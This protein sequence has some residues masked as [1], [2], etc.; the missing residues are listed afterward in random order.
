MKNYFYII[1]I[2]FSLINI[3][4]NPK[5]DTTCIKTI[6]EGLIMDGEVYHNDLRESIMEFSNDSISSDSLYIPEFLLR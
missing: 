4:F 5:K 6:E 3:S 2:I 1:I